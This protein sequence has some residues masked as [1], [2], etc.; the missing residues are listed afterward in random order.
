MEIDYDP[1]LINNDEEYKKGL[2]K[3]EDYINEID[4]VPPTV[5]NPSLFQPEII[6][7]YLQNKRLL[8]NNLICPECN[9]FMSLVKNKASCDKLIWRC[10]KRNPK[11][12]IT[13]NIRRDTIFEGFLIKIQI[14]YYLLF[15]CISENIKVN[16]A[17]DKCNDFCN[18][19]GEGGVAK[20]SI[21]KFYRVVRNR[22][23]EKMHSK[24]EKN[25]LGE[26]I[27]TKLGYG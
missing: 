25:F 1:E 23:R 14:L 12:D 20:E 24:W 16:N 17:Y 3:E 27:N 21:S 10:H 18:Q 5:Y 2:L 22:L 4:E 6:I 19:I 9:N 15:F 8:K 13:I 7:K 11:H 26:E